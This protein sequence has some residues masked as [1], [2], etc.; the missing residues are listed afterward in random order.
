MFW[1]LFPSG[2]WLLIIK[3]HRELLWNIVVVK[4]R[5]VYTA[6]GFGHFNRHKL[7]WINVTIVQNSQ[8]NCA[9]MKQRVCHSSFCCLRNSP[10]PSSPLVHPSTTYTYMLKLDV[11]RYTNVY[12]VYKVYIRTSRN[13]QYIL[14]KIFYNPVSLYVSLRSN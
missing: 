11:G 6:Y 8:Y 9:F 13:G 12:P 7:S 2:P 14:Y 4:Y 10:S 1:S 3:I 5:Y